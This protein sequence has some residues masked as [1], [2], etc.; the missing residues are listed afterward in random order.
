MAPLGAIPRDRPQPYRNRHACLAP[1]ESLYLYSD[2]L[3]EGRDR[4]IDTGLG[5]LAT[6]A[7][8]TR[9]GGPLQA[10]CESLVAEL[11][12]RV[13]DDVCLVVAQRLDPAG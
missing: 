3:V 11:V 9:A 5:L 10:H 6:A 1:G 4:D 7:S 8:R 2:G 12:R 13:E